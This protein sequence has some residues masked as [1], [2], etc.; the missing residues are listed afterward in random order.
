[1]GYNWVLIPGTPWQIVINQFTSTDIWALLN[2]AV[3]LFAALL[4][5]IQQVMICEHGRQ[6]K[7]SML[8]IIKILSINYNRISCI[9]HCGTQLCV[10]NS[11]IT[12]SPI[13]CW[14]PCSTETHKNG[15]IGIYTPQPDFHF[16]NV[17]RVTWYKDI[18]SFHNTECDYIIVYKSFSVYLFW[19][20]KLLYYCRTTELTDNLH[21]ITPHAITCVTVS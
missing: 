20:V 9:V 11:V 10:C 16:Y 13:R 8:F 4:L 12:F 5:A 1:M 7:L 21:S 2:T 19:N 17:H 18:S 6:V 15:G 3:E 14:L